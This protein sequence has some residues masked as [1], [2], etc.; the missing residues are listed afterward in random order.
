MGSQSRNVVKRFFKWDRTSR[1]RVIQVYLVIILV[2]TFL[3]FCF[4]V[5]SFYQQR[6]N[7]ARPSDQTAF[8]AISGFMFFSILAVGLYLL[9]RV[10]WDIR[11]FH[12]RSDFVSGISH[13]FKTPLSLV[14]LYSETLTNDDHDFSP[15]ERKSYIR[16]I[17]RES[18][19]M[20]RMVEN[21]LN[22]SRIEQGKQKPPDQQEGDIA[23]AVRQTVDDYSEYLTW[24]GFQ[25]KS[26]IQPSMPLVRFNH[27]RISQMILN[28]M[29]N[30]VKY[31]GKSRLIRV[32]AWAQN[33]EVV[34]E[35]RDNGFGIPLEEQKM[36]FQPFYRASKG[37]EKGGC[38]LGLYLV[39]QVMKEHGGRVEVESEV[40]QGSR[41]RLIFPLSRALADSYQQGKPID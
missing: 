14:R 15:E 38:G 7:V 9:M 39:D 36:I 6:E 13:E 3:H 1:L 18:E 41:F 29:E 32:N 4:S 31:S 25:V 33:R 27:E 35:V 11:W 21:V 12:L 40:D 22:F 20:S 10:S 16:I 24:R 28:L 34:I 8:I 5:I 19:R 37:S 26:S 30:A 2:F 17:A 23:D